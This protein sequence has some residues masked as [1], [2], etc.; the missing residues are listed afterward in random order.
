MSFLL[1][2]V[3]VENTHDSPV[4]HGQLALGRPHL[5]T[6]IIAIGMTQSSVGLGLEVLFNTRPFGDSR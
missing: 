5:F 4:E 2:K 6:G 3:T 1:N